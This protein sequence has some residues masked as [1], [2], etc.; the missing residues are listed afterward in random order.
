[1]RMDMIG[2]LA[3]G[4]GILT[5]IGIVL[6]SRLRTARTY[7]RMEEM[8]E[9]AV[10]G[11][12]SET[13]FDESRLSA[14]ESRL[15]QYLAAGSVS[16]EKQK[17]REEQISTLISD[18]SHQ[19]RTPVA[20]LKLYAG[21]LEEQPLPPQAEACVGAIRTQSEKLQSLIEAL[22]KT[23]RLE[24][25][26][27]ALHPKRGEIGSVVER[28]V[29]QYAPKASEKKISLTVKSTKGSGVFDPKWT[30]EA[31]CNLLDNAVKYTPSGGSVTVEV[32]EY[33]MFSAVQVTDTGPGI[34]E[35]EQA[36]IFG[37]FYRSP[38]VWQEEGV[39]IGLYLTRQI[40]SGQGGY[41]KV[42]S[43]PGDGSTFSIWLPR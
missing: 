41:V 43:G 19:T 3:A 15:H 36:K 11:S 29:S 13:A 27:L 10:N 5:G 25:G 16:A 7:R 40:A 18:I 8:L 1:M 32:R 38:S 39:G 4:A 20:N 33:E 12:F 22:V 21:L 28:A 34:P 17:K 30:E 37:R 23:S 24:T 9:A 35:E 14:L 31:L 42:K 6:W 2:Y 26:L